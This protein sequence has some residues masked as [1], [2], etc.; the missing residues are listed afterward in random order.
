MAET[1]TA[2]AHLTAA[3]R[4]PTPK[5][6]SATRDG[7]LLYVHRTSNTIYIPAS[8]RSQILNWYHTTLQHPGIKRMQATIKENFYWPGLDTAVEQLV[9]ACPICQQYKITAVNVTV[10]YRFPPVTHASRGRKCT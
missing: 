9:Q 8:L 3:L 4:A 10:R 7:V 5:Y 2:D 6:V 1:Q